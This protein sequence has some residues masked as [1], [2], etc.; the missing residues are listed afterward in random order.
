MIL[1]KYKQT[2]MSEWIIIMQDFSFDAITAIDQ[3]LKCCCNWMNEST[4]TKRF[5]DHTVFLPLRECTRT[6]LPL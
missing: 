6:N 5:I 1:K 2:W 3:Q 4:T